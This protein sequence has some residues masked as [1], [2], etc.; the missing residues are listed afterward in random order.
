MSGQGHLSICPVPLP[1]QLLPFPPP[2]SQGWLGRRWQRWARISFSSHTFFSV[3]GKLLV[4]PSEQK[5]L[6]PLL[7]VSA[8]TWHPLPSHR[9][10]VPASPLFPPVQLCSNLSS[11]SP[12]LNPVLL[13]PSSSLPLPRGLSYKEEITGLK[14][15][16][17][18]L[19]VGLIEI[20][21]GFLKADELP[22]PGTT[23]QLRGNLSTY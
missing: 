2:C 20:A 21:R 11:S 17:N 18:F 1:C 10:S 16:K 5:N 3:P 22:V 6:C 12:N 13:P 14:I 23:T 8:C 9:L 4:A 19:V 15:G 7:A